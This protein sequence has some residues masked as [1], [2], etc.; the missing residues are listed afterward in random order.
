MPSSQTAPEEG[1]PLVSAF[2][3]VLAANRNAQRVLRDSEARTERYIARIT[4]GERAADLARANPASSAR[5]ED[6]EALD[7]FTRARKKSR[8][9][10]FHRLI[11]EGM[12]RKEIAE[13]WGFSEQVVSK[14][15]R[16][17][18]GP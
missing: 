12:S 13:N 1:D 9:A 4:A 6:N 8:S 17:R 18:G 7:W 15:V 11:A 2:E 3:E 5:I 10:V 14:A 16:F